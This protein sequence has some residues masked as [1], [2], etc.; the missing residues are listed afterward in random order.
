MDGVGLFVFASFEAEASE[1]ELLEAL[2]SSLGTRTGMLG[3]W[4]RFFILVWW[5]CASFD[6]APLESWKGERVGGV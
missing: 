5:K 1:P 2:S 4:L 3:E 6:A